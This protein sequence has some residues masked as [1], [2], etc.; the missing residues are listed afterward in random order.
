MDSSTM[1]SN[2]SHKVMNQALEDQEDRAHN[3][4]NYLL[5]FGTSLN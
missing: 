5:K 4:G 2:V 3:E 1:V